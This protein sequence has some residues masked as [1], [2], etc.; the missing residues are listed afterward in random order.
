MLVGW[1]V[2]LPRRLAAVCLGGHA[3][4]AD[5]GRRR[6]CT[7]A[8]PSPDRAAGCPGFESFA[9][10][11][12]HLVLDRRRLSRAGDGR[13]LDV[14][15]QRRRARAGGDP[16]ERAAL[17]VSRHQRV[18]GEDPA[19][20]GHRPSSPPSRATPLPA[21]RWWWR[22]STPGFVFG[23]ELVIWVALGR[24]RHADRPGDRHAAD[25][26]EHRVSERQPAVRVEAHHRARLRRR[27]RG[28]AAGHRAAGQAP[29]PAAGAQ[30]TAAKQ[31]SRRWVPPRKSPSPAWPAAGVHAISLRD[32]RK[33]FGSLLVL[34]GIDF[35]GPARRAAEPGRT[36]RR[37]Q[38]HADALHQ[39][40]W[41]SAPA[42]RCWSTTTTSSASRRTTASPSA[43]GASS[44]TPTSSTR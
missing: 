20:G 3:G 22:P 44:R 17:R 24:A 5:R 36:E 16:R 14:R 7:P 19:A 26:R 12:E 10:R 9:Y 6:S 30:R 40:R 42:A 1:L 39:R 43:S 8:A 23:T 28:A 33:H 13:R 15:A 11:I 25:R 38:D 31:A 27:D 34:E 2:L 4:A 35:T 41:R 37:R 29:V 21:C 32:V 18:A